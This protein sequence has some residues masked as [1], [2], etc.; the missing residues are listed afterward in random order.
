MA[1]GQFNL[2]GTSLFYQVSVSTAFLYIF[3]FFLIFIY[4]S[5]FKPRYSRV[6]EGKVQGKGWLV[7]SHFQMTIGRLTNLGERWFKFFKRD[8]K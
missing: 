3:L 2:T 4:H 5:K 6:M 7:L 1:L 8:P